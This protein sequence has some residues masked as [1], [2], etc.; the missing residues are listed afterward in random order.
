MKIA[1]FLSVSAAAIAAG[2]AA[3]AAAE[4]KYEN[5]S[6][7]SVS[8]Y[9]QFDPAYQFFDDGVSTHSNLVDNTNSNSRVGLWL[10]R[11]MA[12][13]EFSFNFETAL[14]LR[15]STGVSQTGK[16]KW[17]DWQRTSIRKIDLSWANDRWG[18]ISFGQGS[19]ASDGA[20]HADLSGTSVA[21]YN[22]IAD[23][24]GAFRFRTAG[25]ALSGRTVASAFAS[26]DGGRLGRLRY[27]SPAFDGFSIAA[28]YGEEIL[29]TGS[30]KRVADVALRYAGEAGGFRLRGVVAYA[31]TDPGTGAKYHDMVGS[32]SALHDS[33]FNVTLAAGSRNT[34]GNYVYAKLGYRGDWVAA[35]RTSLAIDYYDGADMTVA[36]AQ[37]RSWG[38]AAVQKFD[39]ADV[40]AYL[41]YRSYELGEPGASYRDAASILAGARFR[42]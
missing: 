33:G 13:G 27:D 4:T 23:T 28:S 21:L 12:G 7:G 9:G 19:T 2:L 8:L 14:G 5:A 37:S 18:R 3:P 35:G 42:F 26:F 11:P 32:F 29:R 17:I 1:G 41:A 25:G 24:A 40:E 38:V 6:G 22:N 31:D 36:G 34:S 20:A 15:A 16:P 39:R 30:D 10:R